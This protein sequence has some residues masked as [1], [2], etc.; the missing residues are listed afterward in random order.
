MTISMMSFIVLVYIGIGLGISIVLCSWLDIDSCFVYVAII[1]LWPLVIFGVILGVLWIAIGGI[2]TSITWTIQKFRSKKGGITMSGGSMDYLCYR[3][4]EAA[5][6]MGDR[7]LTELVK[8][9]AELL[10]DREWYI[11]GDYGANT[12]EESVR[13]FKQK[14]FDKPREKR[15]KALIEQMFDETKQECMNMIGVKNEQ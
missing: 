4:E 2:T 14:W 5:S 7:E 13:K 9:V 15:L 12:W 11:S 3:V 10:H 1:L 6:A 8:D